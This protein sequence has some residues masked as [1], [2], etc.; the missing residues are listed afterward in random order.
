MRAEPRVA[1]VT[2]VHDTAE[3][4]PECIESVLAQDYRCFEY[5]IVE[6]WSRDGSGEIAR[7]YAARDRRIRVLS[8]PAFLEQVQNYN[9]ALRQVPAPCR[10]VKL[11]QADDWLFPGCLSQMVQL[12]EAHPRVGIV[13]AYALRGG[14][15]VCDGLP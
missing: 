4:L 8:P 14:E 9:F 7:R 6:N 15:V 10:Y 3:F 11:V 1:V 5:L 13:G 2:P 12:A